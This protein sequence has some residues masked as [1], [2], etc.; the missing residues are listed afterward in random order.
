MTASVTTAW[1]PPCPVCAGSGFT[2][3]V[4]G[5]EELCE[6]CWGEQTAL[7]WTCACC[8]WVFG[9]EDRPARIAPG[10][11]TCGECDSHPTI[12]GLEVA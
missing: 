7:I 10:S 1:P 12:P 5:S 6:S 8:G 3:D 4:P 11:F 9:I 2:P